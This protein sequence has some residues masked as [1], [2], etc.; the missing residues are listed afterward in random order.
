[1]FCCIG[2]RNLCPCEQN[3]IHA[4]R[5]LNEER[6]LLCFLVEKSANRV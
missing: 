1:M 6:I 3:D 5:G 2:M 4:V